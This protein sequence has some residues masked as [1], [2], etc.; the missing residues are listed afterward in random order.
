MA[1]I[2]A[3][4][5]NKTSFKKSCDKEDGIAVHSGKEYISKTSSGGEQIEIQT[6]IVSQN[7][8]FQPVIMA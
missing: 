2:I 8:S 7:M 5:D 3:S 6:P 4:S 1:S